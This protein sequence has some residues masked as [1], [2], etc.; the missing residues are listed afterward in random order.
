MRGTQSLHRPHPTAST[1][2][3]YNTGVIDDR[4]LIVR[5]EQG[6]YCPAGDFHVDPWDPV[7]R[8]VVTHAHSDHATWGCKHYLT[9]ARGVEVLALRVGPAT[10]DTAARNAPIE[11]LP[12]A[13]RRRVGDVWLSLHPAGHVLGSAQVRIERASDAVPDPRVWV[14]SG[15][16]AT[17][18]NETCD[19]FEPVP[20]DVFLT[21]STF[22]L[23]IYRWRPESDVFADLNHWWRENADAGTTTVVLAYALG[24][25]QRVLA[26]LDP[27]IGPIAAHGAV[28]R[29]HDAYTRAGAPLPHVIH[30]NQ[31]TATDLK[32]RA[33]IV[34]P[35]SALEGT[36]IRRFRGP[37]GFATA[38]ASGW[39]SVRGKRRW[40]SV[41][42]GFPLSDH[43]DWDGLNHAIDATGASI[44]G[45][46]HGY[47]E[48]LARWRREQG[49]QS[50]V[51]R[52]RFGDD[53]AAA[54]DT[55]APTPDES[56]PNP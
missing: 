52:T 56:A 29:F 27:S 3:A 34:A 9:S 35:P 39:M 38:F 19:P 23:P 6:L 50:F 36:W 30:A 28:M 37:E 22:A 53:D 32:G 11:A 26:G 51:V 25:A 41:D 31:D 4:S 13:E 44:I 47:A 48:A 12:F 2:D 16:Y 8:A 40:Q 24:K 20:C 7:E 1:P 18:P 5:T 43:A 15:D 33:L 55:D 21:E 42:R 45:A 10:P 54:Q 17:A 14:I 46:T 49:Q